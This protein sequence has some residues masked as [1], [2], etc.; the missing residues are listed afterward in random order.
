MPAY[1]KKLIEVDLPLAEISKES[2]R[3]RAI[4]HG[5][6][7]T[8]HQWWA[9][10]SLSACRAVLFASLV[11][12][13]SEH[14]DEFPT[15]EEQDAERARL[16]KLI[17]ELIKWETTD[18]RQPSSRRIIEQARYEIARSIARSSGDELPDR[19][20]PDSVMRY[21]DSNAKPIYDPFAGG[22]Y[23]PLEAQRL[24][25]H[26]VASDLNPIAVLINKALIELPPKFH[27]CP[28]V[29]PDADQTGMFTG[30]NVGRGRNRK[31][32]QIPWRGAAGLADD[33]RYYGR[34][35]REKALE[36]IG[37]LYPKANLPDGSE[38]TVIAWIWARTIPCPNPACGVK[39]PLTKTF[40]LSKKRNNRHWTKPILDRANNRITFEVQNHATEVPVGDTVN[41]S[42]AIC[43]ACGSTMPVAYV[44]EQ[45]SIK[46]TGEQMI[47]I[48]AEGNRKRLFLSP[49]DK[50]I[51]L[52]LEAE[53][54]RRPS[55][56]MPKRSRDFT[57]T[58]HSVTQWHQ[59]F[60]ERQ[61]V[62][63][64]TFS[65]LLAEV[66][67]EVTED[68]ADSKYADAVCTYLALAIGR[69]ANAWSKF[70][71]WQNAGD[72][73]SSVFKLQAIPM[74]WDFAEV[75]PF[76]HSTNNWMAQI[77]WIANVIRRLPAN[78]NRGTAHQ[79]DASTTIYA[80]NGPVI[81]TDPPYYDNV[82]Y[83]DLSD[84]FYVW[85][86]PALRSI[87]PDLFAGISTPKDEEMIA[88]PTRF[89]N[90]RNRFEKLLT[91]TLRL[92]RN[93]CSPEFPSSI[94]YAYK[95]QEEERAGRT[96]TGWETMLTALV[97]AQF[98]IV[99][100]WPMRIAGGR[101]RAANS[102]ALASS[103]VLVC[104][105][106][107]ED[108]PSATRREFLD[109]L[110]REL[111]VALTRLTHE[112]HIAPVDLAQSAIGPGMEV[113]SR[114][115]AVE[116]ISGEPV[117]VRD[118]LIEINR[119]VDKFHQQE[120]GALDSESRFCLDW[121]DEHGF[122]PGSYGEANTLAQANNVAVGSMSALITARQGSVQLHDM[123]AYNPD[124]P[125]TLGGMTAWEGCF[126]MAYH[127]DPNREDG[128][129]VRGA[130]AIARAL[131]SD[132]DSVERLARILYQRYD[133]RNDSSR[134]ALFNN[135][136]TSWDD[137]MDESLKPDTEKLL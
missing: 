69:S 44:K 5:H 77:D 82:A 40:Q 109:A 97:N 90:S 13:P 21:L 27:N 56:E 10:L 118:A 135:L 2:K 33:I 80:T 46:N 105:S 45:S 93:N 54:T 95:Q 62:A 111:P 91:K 73:V 68:G 78:V 53:S 8:F 113:Y 75:N 128:D 20:Q 103:V 1:T 34:W 79:A 24:G 136:V 25:L 121:H 88:E 22:G 130:G 41:R 110:E 119:V 127:M 107:A 115:G 3:E 61:L 30:K 132:A 64:T 137:I 106:R 112:A 124:R 70:S 100:T 14:T 86:R 131:G 29:N 15:T 96:S 60:S 11:D 66:R 125:L 114:Y 99:G 31:P 43:V 116:T 6:P 122:A 83:A 38:A 101:V 19:E 23:I 72:F 9:R 117:T 55:G 17:V 123:D 126:R 7:S 58:V 108:A 48:V 65:D 16:H 52:A 74:V 67:T 32:E 134:A 98:Q 120:S 47:A 94:F 57:P 104:R 4:R 12:D 51:G 28:P 59:L 26:A 102:N 92:I 49:T 37:H 50:H 81:V 85:L 63:L 76:S 36:R 89:E 71:T 129:T 39:M 87:Y 133:T 84:F 18:E 42:R 35:M